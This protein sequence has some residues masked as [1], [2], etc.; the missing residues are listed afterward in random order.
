MKTNLIDMAT[1]IAV[2]IEAFKGPMPK[3]TLCGFSGSACEISERLGESLAFRPREPVGDYH[4]YAHFLKQCLIALNV[5]FTGSGRRHHVK[6][7]VL[8]AAFAD[9]ALL[10][11]QDSPTARWFPDGSYFTYKTVGDI[12]RII[13]PMAF[14]NSIMSARI[15]EITRV[16]SVFANYARQHYTPRQIFSGILEA[17]PR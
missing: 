17:L 15:P 1:L 2:D 8:E 16:A 4:G 7:R 13:G 11:M 5:S 14:S 9:C 6:W 3:T 10:E 12:K